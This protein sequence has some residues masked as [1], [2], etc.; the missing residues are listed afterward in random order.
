MPERLPA[1]W[2]VPADGLVP[3]KFLGAKSRIRHSRTKKE[4]DA[5]RSRPRALRIFPAKNAHLP[6]NSRTRTAPFRER[7][8]SCCGVFATCLDLY[9]LAHSEEEVSTFGW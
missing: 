3:A 7:P 1:L 5:G 8:H 9:L 2:T 6:T 4:S